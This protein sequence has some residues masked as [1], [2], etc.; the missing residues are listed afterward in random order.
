MLVR[1][2]VHIVGKLVDVG[3]ELF[4]SVTKT[5]LI[6]FGLNLS[7]HCFDHLS[8]VFKSWFIEHS[9]SNS[10][11]KCYLTN[12]ARNCPKQKVCTLITF[13]QKHHSHK[14]KKK[15]KGPSTD[16]WGTPVLIA[17]LER[18]IQSI[19]LFMRTLRT[20]KRFP[21]ILMPGLWAG[22]GRTG[23]LFSVFQALHCRETW[24][25]TLSSW[26]ISSIFNFLATTGHK[27]SFNVSMYTYEFMFPL[28]DV[29]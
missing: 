19:N 1:I 23:I 21:D 9:I 2:L 26:K 24:H 20:L 8:Y 27:L 4:L 16:P 5:A 3:S 18:T 28:M 13:C 15:S 25:G 22:H 17:L 11:N 12:I 6:L 7:N 14:L 10:V 29:S